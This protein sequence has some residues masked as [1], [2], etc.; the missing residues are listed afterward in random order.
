MNRSRHHFWARLTQF[1]RQKSK[2]GNFRRARRPARCVKKNAHVLEAMVKSRKQAKR[3][4]STRWQRGLKWG[5]CAAVIL[6]LASTVQGMLARHFWNSPDLLVSGA[7]VRTNGALTH[8]EILRRAGLSEAENVYAVDLRAARENLEALP[9]VR[10]ASVERELPGRLVVKVDERLPLAWLSC[11][12][13]SL[14]P[15]TTNGHSGGC[16]VDE[17]GYLF[18]CAELR[19]SLMKLPVIH[20]RRLPNAQPGIRLASES[21]Q[22]GLALI[23]AIRTHFGARGLD[24]VEIDAPND[25]SLVAK[26]TDDSVITFGYDDVDGQFARLAHIMDVCAGK[27]LSLASVNLLPRKNVPVTFKGGAIPSDFPLVA[28]ATAAPSLQPIST[29]PASSQAPPP[30]S[31]NPGTPASQLDEILGS[32]L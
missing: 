17:E 9:N 16:L 32:G 24:V 20:V 3:E 13:P 21:V 30:S 15:F 6:F 11:D 27:Q 1:L 8:D 19:P 31:K 18:R 4:R 14:Q 26:L 23:R 28:A 25:W 12:A 5:A 29:A 22:G 7:D 2:L 10:R